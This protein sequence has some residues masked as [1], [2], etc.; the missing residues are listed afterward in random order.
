MTNKPE[1]RPTYTRK[2]KMPLVLVQQVFDMGFCT[3]FLAVF[4]NPPSQLVAE[5]GVIST[6]GGGC[7][8]SHR[9]EQLLLC[10]LQLLIG[11]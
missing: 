7:D 5:E 6:G 4:L 3:R 9:R 1:E 10:L 2:N 11:Y 8:D